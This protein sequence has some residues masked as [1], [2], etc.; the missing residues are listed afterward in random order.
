MAPR[1]VAI[2]PNRAVGTQRFSV[3]D[4]SHAASTGMHFNTIIMNKVKDQMTTKAIK[5]RA[6]QAKFELALKMRRYIT[7]MDSLIAYGSTDSTRCWA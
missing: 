2:K 1:T 3:T 5:L 6:I 7:K 4:G